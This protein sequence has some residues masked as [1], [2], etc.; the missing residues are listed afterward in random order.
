MNGINRGRAPRG[1]RGLKPSSAALFS[2]GRLS[3][4]AW[5]AW[6]ET[7]QLP[8]GCRRGKSRAP[9]GARGLKRS[10]AAAG[11]VAAAVAPRVGRVD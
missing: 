4:P 10:L 11:Q 5:G 8:A 2:K 3:R 6:I 9:R 1:A 7:R